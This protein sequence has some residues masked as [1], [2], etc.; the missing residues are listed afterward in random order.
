MEAA[1]RAEGFKWGFISVPKVKTDGD[2]YASAFTEEIYIP[3][4]AENVE[5]AKE[6]I[7]FLYSDKAVQIF[8]ENGGAIQPTKNALD[9]IPEGSEQHDYYNIYANGAKANAVGFAATEQVEGVNLTDGSGILYGTVNEVVIG[10]KTVDEWYNEVIE[11]V[12]KLSK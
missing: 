5:L 3:D 1:P 8:A 2:T 7:A 11:A 12:K 10:E 6:F 9:L 4:G